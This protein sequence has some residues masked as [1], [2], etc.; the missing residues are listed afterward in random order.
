MV[1]KAA[2]TAVILFLLHSI[3]A[4]STYTNLVRFKTAFT[5]SHYI[6]GRA[7]DLTC[8]QFIEADHRGNKNHV[9]PLQRALVLDAKK[10]RKRSSTS[11]HESF[12]DDDRDKILSDLI[13]KDDGKRVR[14]SSV[15]S[16]E[17]TSGEPARTL[18]GGPS[19]IFEMARRMLVWDDELYQGLNDASPD[20]DKGKLLSTALSGNANP[21]INAPRWRPSPLLQRSISN[22]NPAFRTSSPIMTSAGYAGILRRNSRK[23]VKPSMWRHT[24]RVYDKMA[25]LEKITID[26]RSDSKKKA[27]RRRSVHHEAALVAAS[28]LG[29]WEQA[30]KIYRDV[31]DMPI[32]SNRKASMAVVGVGDGNTNSSDSDALVSKNLRRISGVTDNMILSVISACVKGSYVKRTTNMISFPAINTT[33]ATSVGNN[34]NNFASCS[35]QRTVRT[36]TIEERRR[37]LDAAREILL[38]IEVSQ[39]QFSLQ[40]LPCQKKFISV[41]L[42]HWTRFY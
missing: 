35:S 2:I 4:D 15:S 14:S 18:S 6:C 28:K 3:Y 39:H 36:L 22:V 37:P 12:I 1:C 8:L 21:S 23:K 41:L 40:F 17:L 30:I 31:E 34:S 13:A 24:L 19:L 33:N 10:K 5:F 29:A 20:G 26:G 27:I 25:D 11:K 7:S 32:S 42:I 38:S 16:S 9:G